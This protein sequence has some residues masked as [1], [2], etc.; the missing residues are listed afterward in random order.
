MISPLGSKSF[1]VNNIKVELL[2]VRSEFSSNAYTKAEMFLMT[3]PQDC[4]K[5]KE[6]ASHIS[7]SSFLICKGSFQLGQLRIGALEQCRFLNH[8]MLFSQFGAKIG[9]FTTLKAS[10]LN[11]LGVLP[12]YFSG[13]VPGSMQRPK[14]ML[15]V[16]KKESSKSESSAS[17]WRFRKIS[18]NF[19]ANNQGMT[20]GISSTWTIGV[21]SSLVLSLGSTC[22][23]VHLG[24]NFHHGGEN[25]N[26]KYEGGWNSRFCFDTPEAC[27]L[28]VVPTILIVGLVVVL[29]GRET[30]RSNLVCH[31]WRTVT[32][33]SLVEIC[34]GSL[35]DVFLDIVT[36]N[37]AIGG[38]TIL[39][40]HQMK[41][42][43]GRKSSYSLLKTNGHA[44]LIDEL[45][46]TCFRESLGILEHFIQKV[47]TRTGVQ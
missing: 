34:C 21:E 38:W 12:S 28:R 1:C 46:G 4:T 39:S 37:V 23:F 26:L 25:P 9:V 30:G 6:L 32:G 11:G 47:T 29:H 22:P 14:G 20:T 2:K 31:R 19:K 35:R 13:N 41:L 15:A 36:I 45:F 24:F 27:E 3:L 42:A 43:A 44:S 33:I 16:G 10:F 5:R 8:E 17:K 40:I 18:M 7:F